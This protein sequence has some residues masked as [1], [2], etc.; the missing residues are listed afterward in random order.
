GFHL[1]K[2]DLRQHST[3]HR[4]AV[5]ELLAAAGIAPDYA[6]LDETGRRAALARAFA[7]SETLAAAG[8][9]LG[10][11][12][13][14]TLAAFAAMR[15]IQEWVGPAGCD[16]YLI[17]MAASASDVLDVLLLARAAPGGPVARIM[18][19]PLFE[20]LD[21]LR[22]APPI[23]EDLFADPIYRRHLEGWD[24]RQEV[25]LGYSDSNKDA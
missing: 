10:P 1:A 20:T 7:E 19:A 16:T 6:D 15:R 8:R 24:R 23:L 18:V 22:A 4:A 12:A 11:E 2:L 13:T 3:R 14:E 9:S 21:D 25:M 17:S 5:A